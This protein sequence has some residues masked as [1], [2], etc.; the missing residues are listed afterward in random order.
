METAPSLIAFGSLAPLPAPD[1]LAQLRDSLRQRPLLEPVIEA[2]HELA[3][4]RS[5]QQPFDF[6][7]Y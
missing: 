5:H 1:R 6:I 4:D 3:D 2:I 7:P